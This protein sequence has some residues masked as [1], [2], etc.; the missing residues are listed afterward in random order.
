MNPKSEPYSKKELSDLLRTLA[1]GLFAT[2]APQP[3]LTEHALRLSAIC[4][5][6]SERDKAGGEYWISV[7]RIQ[8]GRLTETLPG[9]L[10][11]AEA[12]FKTIRDKFGPEGAGGKAAEIERCQ[13]KDLVASMAFHYLMAAFSRNEAETFRRITELMEHRQLDKDVKSFP[14]PTGK[15]GKPKWSAGSL[16]NFFVVVFADAAHKL[17][18]YPETP[19]EWICTGGKWQTV[20]RG[21]EILSWERIKF[22]SLVEKV[23][24]MIQDSIGA[25]KPQS[26]SRRV[27]RSWLTD[28]NLM[29][30]VDDSPLKKPAKNRPKRR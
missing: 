9:L 19:E 5:I 23:G 18:R 29:G 11:A 20:E 7:M 24:E 3:P 6:L 17:F 22:S 28:N 4:R 27:L 16:E 25:E 14:V 8:M 21:A 12:S 13:Q 30:F 10:L 15:K 26:F 2:S 1:T